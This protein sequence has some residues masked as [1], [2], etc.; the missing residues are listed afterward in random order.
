MA[1]R[2]HLLPAINFFVV[3]FA[4]FAQDGRFALLVLPGVSGALLYVLARRVDVGVA[5]GIALSMFCAVFCFVANGCAL[6]LVGLAGFYQT[7]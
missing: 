5:W 1:R 3:L 4:G 7:F 6:F 2:S